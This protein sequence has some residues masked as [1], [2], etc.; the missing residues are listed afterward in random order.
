MPAEK[1]F[2]YCRKA[3]EEQARQPSGT[4]LAEQEEACRRYCAENDLTVVSVTQEI[5]SGAI[6]EERPQFMKMRTQCLNGEV[7]GIVVATPDRLCRNREHLSRLIDEMQAHHVSLI[8]VK[9]Q[10]VLQA[11]PWFNIL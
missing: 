11:I 5:A 7:G 9:G 8:C 6:W 10:D 2:I 1:V 4:T 3:T